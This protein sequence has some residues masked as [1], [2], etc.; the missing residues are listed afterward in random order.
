[1]N[2]TVLGLTNPDVNLKRMHQLYNGIPKEFCH[3][4]YQNI[5]HAESL[6]K[7][8]GKNCLLS[9]CDIQN[10]YKCIPISPVD[11]ELQAFCIDGLFYYDKT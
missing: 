4:Q 6:M 8:F 1:M 5:N 2:I 7:K 3:V 10:A 11:N 9:K